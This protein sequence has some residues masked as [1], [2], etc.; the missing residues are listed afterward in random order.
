L[1]YN[2]AHWR[3][4]MSLKVASGALNLAPSYLIGPKIDPDAIVGQMFPPR[5]SA[6]C[7]TGR[8]Y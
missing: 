1:K 3:L 6:A 5:E 4:R 7:P 2:R 8:P